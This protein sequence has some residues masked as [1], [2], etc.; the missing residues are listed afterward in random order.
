MKLTTHCCL[1]WEASE[2]NGRVFCNLCGGEVDRSTPWDESHIGAPKAL[3]GSRTGVAHRA[4]NQLDNVEH[5]RPL[6]I[7]ANHMRDRH[8]G[9]TGPGL[10][11][12]PLPAGRRSGITKRLNGKI[13]PRLTGAQKHQRTMAALYPFGRPE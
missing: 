6:I 1:I 4:C 2:I 3:G 8:L 13:E 10:S 5:V 7:K 11:D 9:I 12:T